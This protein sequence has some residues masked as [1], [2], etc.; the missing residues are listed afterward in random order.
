MHTSFANADAE[1]LHLA[2]EV[3]AF[4]A[5][6]FGGA[7]DIVAG[8][9]NLLEDIVALVSV[10]G[11]LESGEVLFSARGGFVGEWRKL[12]ALDAKRARIENQDTLDHI[13]QLTYV[14]G[15]VILLKDAERFVA[16]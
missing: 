2:I 1:G 8:F 6:E 11:L 16:D 9:L 10:T 15:P 14:A 7:T 3:T 5:E 4:K 12:L 13:F